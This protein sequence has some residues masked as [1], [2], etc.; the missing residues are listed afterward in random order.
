MRFRAFSSA[1][2]ATT[3]HWLSINDISASACIRGR[4]TVALAASSQ[5]TILLSIFLGQFLL[6]GNVTCWA[7]FV[8]WPGRNTLLATLHG[9]STTGASWLA[10]RHGISA[11]HERIRIKRIR[12]IFQTTCTLD[13]V[14]HRLNGRHANFNIE[15]L[16]TGKKCCGDVW[17]LVA[18]KARQIVQCLL[19]LGS[20]IL[21]F[22]GRSGCRQEV[23]QFGVCLLYTSPSPRDR[24]KSRMPSS[25]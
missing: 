23:A 1:T 24:Q 7:I 8:F 4:T 5:L 3:S 2:T 22:L 16:E 25:A 17:V 12:W 14:D 15:I 19:L 9:S 6:L 13:G 10:R 18:S 21:F 20:Q 11:P